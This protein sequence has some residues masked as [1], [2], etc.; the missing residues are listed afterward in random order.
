MNVKLWIK[1]QCTDSFGR[2]E[3]KMIIGIP[4]TILGAISG[5]LGLVNIIPSFDWSGWSIFMGFSC[6]LIGV[7]AVTD[8]INDSRRNEPPKE[9]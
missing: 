4:M 2:P 8:A 9:L 6:G 3:P 1:E 5:L 7:T